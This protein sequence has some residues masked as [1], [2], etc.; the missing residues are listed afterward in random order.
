MLINLRQ[1][2]TLS[3]THTVIDTLSKNTKS[4][5]FWI[6]F[7]SCQYSNRSRKC[8]CKSKTFVK[9]SAVQRKLKQ[10]Y[11]TE[12]YNKAIIC[13]TKNKTKMLTLQQYLCYIQKI[14]SKNHFCICVKINT[15]CYTMKRNQ[16]NMPIFSLKWTN[17]FFLL[18]LNND[19]STLKL[20]SLK[21][22]SFFSHAYSW[23]W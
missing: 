12:F 15:V 23:K 4:Y 8:T 21:D 5:Q 17:I 19:I 11:K 7:F 1:V 22:F 18:M 16:R 14:P 10:E 9:V 20:I 2:V 13:F 3:N 6:L